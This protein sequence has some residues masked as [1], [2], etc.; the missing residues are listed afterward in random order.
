M[1]DP[2]RVSNAEAEYANRLRALVADYEAGFR[3]RLLEEVILPMTRQEMHGGVKWS[4]A[5]WF[6]AAPFDAQASLV[7]DRADVDLE[8]PIPAA[9]GTWYNAER[10]HRDGRVF[11]FFFGK[12][13]LH[14]IVPAGSTRVEVCM[15][16]MVGEEVEAVFA[17]HVDGQPAERVSVERDDLGRRVFAFVLP[18][19]VAEPRSLRIEFSCAHVAIPARV[20]EGST[21]Q[22]RLSA[23]L[24]EPVFVA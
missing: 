17:L 9:C 4:D 12:A 5:G 24:C 1:N 21:D 15:P 8:F 20:H 22:R 7:A 3:Q 14:R 6:R 11:R 19:A 13:W 10:D 23:A 16:H 2:T 18:V